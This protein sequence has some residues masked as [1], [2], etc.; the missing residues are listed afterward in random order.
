MHSTSEEAAK[1]AKEADVLKLVL[2]HISSRYS[3]NPTQLLEEAKKIFD[4]VIVANDLMEL[5]V[6]FRDKN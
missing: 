2:T 5:D 3:D 6:P 4:N 1:L